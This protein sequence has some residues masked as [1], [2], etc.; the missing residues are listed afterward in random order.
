[1]KRP[2]VLITGAAKRLGRATA[3]AFVQRGCNVMLHYNHS[4][5]AAE[6]LQ[7]ELLS[8]YPKCCQIIQAELN[9]QDSLVKIVEDT[10]THFGRL[11]HLVNNASIFYPTT[12]YPTT[13][14][15]DTEI[16]LSS[17]LQTNYV[18]PKKLALL[19][20]P[21][22]A[23][24]K[25]SI[26]NLID[27]YA[28]AGLSEHTAYVASK[29]ALKATT[30][31]QAKQFSPKVR[32]NGIS[33][34]AILWPDATN[35]SDEKLAESSISVQ[36]QQSLPSENKKDN[37]LNNTAL[38]RLGHPEN[39]AATAVYLALDACYTTGSVINVD[40]GRRDYI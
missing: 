6:S 9:H 27:I 20:E 25:G 15:N 28:D 36:T 31:E 40:G 29:S 10:L 35:F 19:A 34:G 3:C 8:I 37:I 16:H 4:I 11:D 7:F 1:M 18:A 17:F 23:K 12:F 14:Q 5:Q 38:K 30:Q 26:V 13:L 22:I 39:I 24:T 21:Y 32:V 33:P 2:T